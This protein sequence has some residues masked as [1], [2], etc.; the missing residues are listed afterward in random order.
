MGIASYAVAASAGTTSATLLKAQSKAETPYINYKVTAKTTNRTSNSVKVTFAI[1]SSLATSTNYFGRPFSLQ[2]SIYIGGTWH[3]VTLKKSTEFWRGQTGHTVNL[4][5]TVTGLTA[6]TA[7][8]TDIKFKVAR[9]DSIGGQSGILAATNCSN[10]KISTYATA[11]PET[12]YLQSTDYGT[13]SNWHGASI[14]R[15]IPTDASG[16]VGAKNFSLSYSQKMSI[17]SGN[18]A[19]SELGAFQVLLVSGSGTARKIV[20]GVNIYKSSSGKKGNL[21]FYLNG[22]VMETISIDLSHN[23]KYFNSSKSSKITKNGGTVTFDIC[24][25]KKTFKDSDIAE[26]LVNEVTFTFS[27]YGTKTPLTYNGLYWVKFVK[28]NCNTLKDIPNKFSANDILIANCKNA[29]ITLNGVLT[30]SLGALGNDWEDFYLTPGLNQIGI[31]YSE[32]VNKDY[33]PSLKVRY[34][35]VFL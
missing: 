24:G 25:V 30:P 22:S 14:T 31:V 1:T 33:A 26:T 35:E 27:K 13:G 4:T 16:E 23:N 12:Y 20:A 11:T 9:T 7:T 17:G 8:L 28:N 21:R 19:K 10:L 29:E 5:V 32:W 18:N 2:G 34:R 6:T 15:V 3:N